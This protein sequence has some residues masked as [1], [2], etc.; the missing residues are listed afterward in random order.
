MTKT[1]ENLLGYD[2]DRELRNFV[3][4]FKN[5][6]RNLNTPNNNWPTNNWNRNNYNWPTVA[7]TTTPLTPLF[8]NWLTPQTYTTDEATYLTFDLPGFNEKNLTVEITDNVLTIEG[9]R[10]YGYGENTYTRTVNEN[11]SLTTYEYDSTKVNAELTNGVLTIT[12]PKNKKDKK[13]T[14]TLI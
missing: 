12:L 7:G 8:T 4:E 9:K 13:K 3:N 10:E 14:V 2:F 11:L 5:S 1:L 6:T